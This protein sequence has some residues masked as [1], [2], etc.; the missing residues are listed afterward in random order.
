MSHALVVQTAWL[1]DAVLT[2]PLVRAVG[3]LHGSVD[4]VTRPD[5]APLLETHP[6]VRHVIPYDKRGADRGLRGLVRVAGVLRQARY[7]IA[8]LAQD[9][10]RSAALAWLAAIPERVGFA[11]APGRGCYTRHVQRAGAHEA[12]RLLALSGVEAS[13]A[14]SLTLTDADREGAARA[15]ARSAID[16]PFAV[17]A[18]GSARATKRWPHYDE[19]ATSLSKTV[20]VVFVGGPGNARATPLPLCPSH[21]SSA[22][23]TGRLAIRESAAVIE[24][25]SLVVT[26]DSAALHIAQAVG[27]PVVALF[28]P[29]ALSQ[30]FGPRGEHDTALGLDLPCRPCSPHGDEHCPLDHHR[31]L[32]ELSPSTVYDAVVRVVAGAARPTHRSPLTAH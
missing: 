29:T 25:A 22:D 16:G 10:L 27:T 24:C 12:D 18:P 9:S 6:A 4:V 19:L 14:L 26:N 17:L 32:R 11:D 20:S 15:L 1:G 30:G 3:A 23:L 2:S 5:T 7:Q 8:Y 21:L 28:G 31:C 13:S